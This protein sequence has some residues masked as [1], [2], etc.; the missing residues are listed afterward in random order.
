VS[1]MFHR[2]VRKGLEF[3]TQPGGPSDD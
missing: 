2:L 3:L 1:V